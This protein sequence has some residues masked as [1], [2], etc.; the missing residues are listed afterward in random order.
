MTAQVRQP[1]M[2]SRHAWLQLQLIIRAIIW[3]LVLVIMKNY[4]GC[5]VR[6]NEMMYRQA[7]SRFNTSTS[8]SSDSS[9]CTVCTLYRIVVVV[10]IIVCVSVRLTRQERLQYASCDCSKTRATAAQ[11]IHNYT[12]FYQYYFGFQ[13]ILQSW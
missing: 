2:T 4:W 11:V 1:T 5:T 12:H 10:A 13:C 3:L 9:S 8:S 7:A 6:K